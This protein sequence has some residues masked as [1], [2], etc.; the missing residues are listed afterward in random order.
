MDLKD[1]TLGEE[2]KA[3][4]SNTFQTLEILDIKELVNVEVL[5]FSR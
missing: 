1:L 3:S 4:S 5:F 2:E